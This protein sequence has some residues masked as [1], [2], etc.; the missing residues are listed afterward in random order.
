MKHPP[1]HYHDYL[2]LN[3]LLN[4]Q[5]LRSREVGQPAHDEML[6]ITVHQT[7]ELWFKQI[8]FELDSVRESL[9][10]NPVPE[11]N[12]GTAIHRL[13]RIVDILKFS[14]GQVDILETMT[15]LD[16]LDFRDVLYPASGFQS[17]QFRLIET[18]LGLRENDRLLYNQVPFYTH[19]PP[20]QQESVK[21]ALEQPS[22]HD[23][24][25][26]WLERTPFLQSKNFDFWMIYKN[27]VMEMLAEDRQVVEESPRLTPQEKE[28]NLKMNDLTM[29]TFQSLFD[30]KS[31][32][33]LRQAGQFRLSAPAVHAALF[34]QIY[35][36]EPILQQPFRLLSLLLDLDEVMTSWRNRHAQMV[37]RMLGRK[38]G[39]G[40][41]SGHDYLK[42][43]A[44]RH[45]I[46]GDFMRL[47]TYLIPRSKIPP[48]PED[49]RQRMDFTS[50]SSAT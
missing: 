23:L 33:E 2:R 38:I 34:I 19:L 20:A 14:I 25:E 42:E 29:T 35:R 49:L 9:N 41:S 47:A 3:D 22:L 15:P 46:F 17:V 26:K 45:K 44:D 48:L 21:A 43:T 5:H 28:R 39:T 50:T 11:R 10:A 12:L 30:R 40:G 6:F 36:D 27:A 16:F 32:E 1:V 7:Y 24:V 18:K 8:L 4:A 31:F 37:S 13:S